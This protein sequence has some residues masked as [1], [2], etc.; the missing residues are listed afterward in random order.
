MVRSCRYYN[1]E[2][3]TSFIETDHLEMISSRNEHFLNIGL[4]PHYVNT[5][6]SPKTFETCRIKANVKDIK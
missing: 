1:G 6:I 5:T 2:T 3:M 4:K